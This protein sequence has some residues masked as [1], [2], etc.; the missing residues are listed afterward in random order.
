M[1]CYRPVIAVTILETRP[2]DVLSD[3][4]RLTTS[5]ETRRATGGHPKINSSDI[6][7]TL[8]IINNFAIDFQ[9]LEHEIRMYNSLRITTLEERDL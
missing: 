2:P 5:F 9:K 1:L 6:F 3:R 8:Y 4:L 7:Y